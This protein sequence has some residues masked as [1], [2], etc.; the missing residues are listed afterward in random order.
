VVVFITDAQGTAVSVSGAL[1]NLTGQSGA[2]VLAISGPT[3]WEGTVELPDTATSYTLWARQPAP[4][5]S[6]SGFIDVN[7][8]HQWDDG[9]PQRWL[10][11]VDLSNGNVTGADLIFVPDVVL[12]SPA[13]GSDHPGSTPTFTWEAYPTTAA[14]QGNWSYVLIATSGSNTSGNPDMAW[15]VDN[16]TTAFDLS[17][18]PASR[19]DILCAFAGGTYDVTNGCTGAP[20]SMSDLGTDWWIWEVAVLACPA[21]DATCILNSFTGSGAYAWSPQWTVASVCGPGLVED[22]SGQ[23]VNFDACALGAGGNPCAVQGDTA[24]VCTDDAPPSAS[25]QCQCGAGYQVDYDPNT[26]DPVCAPIP[27]QIQARPVSP[28]SPGVGETIEVMVI[29]WQ[30][31][32]I[33]DARLD[34]QS[35]DPASPTMTVA[36]GTMVSGGGTTHLVADVDPARGTLDVNLGPAPA[37]GALITITSVNYPNARFTMYNAMCQ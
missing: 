27:P 21:S 1:T 23:C 13:D 24:A 33:P 22:M 11:N 15:A 19:N 2:F 6:V 32:P 35:A 12:L 20:G 30:G 4:G 28:C 25:Y 26:N 16:T 8:N 37:S 36:L 3:G 18:P 31:N 29:D 9:E 5:Y 17:A 14:P 34:L 10:D 7:G